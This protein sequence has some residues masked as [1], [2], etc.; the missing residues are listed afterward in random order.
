[1]LF[2]S[3]MQHF[4]KKVW[5]QHFGRPHKVFFGEVFLFYYNTLPKQAYQVRR[6]LI[7]NR[8]GLNGQLLF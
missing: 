6:G 8:Q 7:G 5:G 4:L 3:G 1:M 2:T